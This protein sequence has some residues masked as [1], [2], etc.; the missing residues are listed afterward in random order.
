MYY[1]YILQSDYDST[2]Y[3]GYTPTP[4]KRLKEHNSSES[5]YT[6]RKQ[7]WKLVYLEINEDKTTAIKREKYLK[8]QKNKLW[9]SRLI[10]S[11]SNILQE[12]LKNK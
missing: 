8:K 5:G 9:Y 11:D 3:I 7:P 12:F 1:T 6:S 4:L 2:Y 10:K